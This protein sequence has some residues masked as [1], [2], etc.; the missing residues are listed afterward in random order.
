[1]QPH[2]AP[3]ILTL[4]LDAGSQ[5]H[6]NGLRQRYFPPERNYLQ[7]H[8]T[9]FH[10]LPG[11]QAAALSDHLAQV[12]AATSPLPL[13]VAGLR[14]L[15][16]GVAYQLHT[17]ELQ[18]LHQALQQKWAAWLTP[19]DQ[20][21]L[22]PHVTVQNKV[23]PAVARAL[24]QELTEQF[25]PFKATGT[26]FTLWLYRGGPWEELQQFRFDGPEVLP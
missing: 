7:A 15:G 23:D 5:Q 16:R 13:Q 26:G 8:V 6:F 12:A 24:H 10:H 20:Q 3:L 25:Q 19:Q 9:L 2:S 18:V 22:K 4:A 17:P 1:M 11:A 14:F 21:R